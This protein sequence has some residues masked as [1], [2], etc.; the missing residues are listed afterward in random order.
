M[1][2]SIIA[3]AVLMLM[4]MACQELNEGNRDV[5]ENHYLSESGYD[6][7]FSKAG[8][9]YLRQSSESNVSAILHLCSDSITALATDSDLLEQARIW[10]SLDSLPCRI[11]KKV[12]RLSANGLPGKVYC[13][14]LFQG[15]DKIGHETL[16]GLYYFDVKLDRHMNPYGVEATHLCQGDKIS[17]LWTI[18]FVSD[19]GTTLLF[20]VSSVDVDLWSHM[21][22]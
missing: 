4:G 2:S 13:Y 17:G 15:Y 14:Q 11:S 9:L 16:S 1:R 12:I 3:I 18:R 22:W 19:E 8:T 20:K 21:G 10:F 5:S 7:S 6:I